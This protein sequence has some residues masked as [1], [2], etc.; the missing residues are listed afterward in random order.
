MIVCV[1]RPEKGILDLSQ[2]RSPK[3]KRRLL[4]NLEDKDADPEAK[5]RSETPDMVSGEGQSRSLTP[6]A[7][8]QKLGSPLAAPTSNPIMRP[9]LPPLRPEQ[10]ASFGQGHYQAPYEQPTVY[11]HPPSQ[12]PISNGQRRQ[13]T[14]EFEHTI[15]QQLEGL[16]FAVQQV[17]S[18]PPDGGGHTWSPTATQWRNPMKVANG[19]PT[20]PELKTAPLTADASQRPPW[21][22][23][24]SVDSRQASP[25]RPMSAGAADNSWHQASAGKQWPQSNWRRSVA[26]EPQ[27]QYAQYQDIDETPAWQGPSQQGPQRQPQQV[28]QQQWRPEPSYEQRFEPP[29]QSNV[30]RRE[31]QVRRREEVV[32]QESLN[33]NSF[34]VRS[35]K[36]LQDIQSEWKRFFQFIC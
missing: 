11:H 12:Q 26:W 2:I 32:R 19:Q 29:P 35:E 20:S 34:T 9:V 25:P 10:L 27:R 31:E 1:C 8:G 3:M 14:Q 23:T 6:D 7:I 13:N 24:Q 4:K 22:R 15:N 21:E 18:P 17:S 16:N 28:P 33:R 36:L 30:F 5:A